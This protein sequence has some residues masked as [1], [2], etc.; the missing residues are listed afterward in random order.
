MKLWNKILLGF[1]LLVVISIILGVLYSFGYLEN[2][3][4]KSLTII[5]AAVSAPFVMIKNWLKEHLFSSAS[6]D[7]IKESEEIYLKL[8]LAEQEKR[9][10]LNEI[11]AEKDKQLEKLQK[12]VGVLHLEM[13]DLQRQR[14]NVKAEV[15]KLTTNEVLTEFDEEF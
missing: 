13:N 11:I 14:K 10:K 1:L 3:N 5:G 7:R 6:N 4:W 8:R 9:E 12:E 15:E 2:T